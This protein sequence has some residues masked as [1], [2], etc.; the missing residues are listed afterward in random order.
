MNAFHGAIL[1]IIQG[2]TEF[3]PVSSSGHLVIFQHI[4]GLKEPE[5]FFDISVH[6]GTLAAIIVLFWRDIHKII[7]SVFR[8][9]KNPLSG[10]ENDPDLKLAF[11]IIAG[12]VP[13]AII[14]LLFNEIKDKLF[15]SITLVGIMLLIT[16]LMLL[17]TRWIKKDRK[18]I[19]SFS[20]TNAIIIGVIQ[21]LAILPGISRSGSTI[22]TALFLGIDRATAARYSFLL[23]IPAIIGAELLSLR[24][25]AFDSII[26]FKTVFIGTAAS[27]FVGYFALVL[28]MH[29]VKKGRFYIFAPYCFIVGIAALFLSAV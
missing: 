24:E 3:L 15:S 5:L 9:L 13:T 25:V 16:G 1:G 21:G 4:F 29:I 12:S 10:I 2:L 26:S 27:F 17:A 18:G 23:S 7:M 14:G 28:L 22:S 11:L 6:M 19:A 20:M 8:F